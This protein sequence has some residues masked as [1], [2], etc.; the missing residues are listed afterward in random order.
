MPPHSR[1]VTPVTSWP[2]S[3]SIGGRDR[4]VDAT[5]HR[6]H[7]P[8]H[9]TS[10]RTR[11]R[12]D[13]RPRS[14]STAR[15]TISSAR[16]TSSLEDVA[17]RLNR[18]GVAGFVASDAHREP[19][20]ATARPRPT[21]TTTRR[22]AH[23]VVVEGDQQRLGR[24]AFEPEVM[25]AGHRAG[26]VAVD[27]RAVD[28]IESDGEP[29]AQRGDARDRRPRACSVVMRSAAAMPTMPATFTVP[30]RRPR[31]WP[32]PIVRGSS[33]TPPRTTSTPT[34]FGPPN[35]WADTLTRSATAV[36]SAT[37]SHGTAW[38]ASVCSTAWGA[39]SR[40][41][42]DDGV[43]R[44]DGA[45]LVVHQHHRDDRRRRVE[46][47]GQPV[48]VDDPV[49]ADADVD[50]VVSLDGE[51]VGSRQDPLV[52]ERRGHDPAPARAPRR[53]GRADDGEVVGLRAPRGEHDL[54]GC[55]A[56]LRRP[57]ARGRS[58][59]RSSPAGRRNA[60]PTGSRTCP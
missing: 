47:G 18:N 23:T 22:R 20:R 34:P 41:S 5:A 35:L 44:L 45:D 9:V 28:R 16:S 52:L 25:V 1:S 37:G 6:N 19:T 54:R 3:A 50:D 31:S 17:P 58:R 56:Q 42:V 13:R 27:D 46:R 11:V 30:D 60:G 48:E 7:H 32:P 55:T 53:V 29:V 21:R 40:T 59:G 39:R 51:E 38:T 15:G 14:C 36:S 2:A 43:E 33:A 24:D 49:H 12:T 4:R 8:H 26:A 57:P 10:S